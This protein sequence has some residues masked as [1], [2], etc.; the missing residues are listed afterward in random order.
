[1][2]QNGRRPSVAMPAA[3]VTACCSAMPTSKVRSGNRLAKRSRPVPLGM[4]AVT[5]TM[6]S[7]ASAS[8]ISAS[9]NTLVYCG[10]PGGAL[11]C[12]PVTTLNLLTACS[13]S[14]VASAGA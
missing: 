7:S 1:M 2:A 5:A 13:L 14:G 10:W 8:W 12:S 3:K 6:R 9:A 4:A 11:A